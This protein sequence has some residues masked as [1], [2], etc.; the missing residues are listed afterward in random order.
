MAQI[1]PKVVDQC[2]EARDFLGCA[3]AFTSPAVPDDGLSALRD[4]M[5]RVASRLS[6]GTSLNNSSSTF[7]PVIDA[8]A[9]VPE[10]QQ[11]S[12]AYQSASMAIDLFDLTQ[13]V[14]QSRI[15]NTALSAGISNL[16]GVTHLYHQCVSFRNQVNRSFGIL[17]K[18]VPWS[19]KETGMFGGRCNLSGNNPEKPLCSYVVGILREGATNPREIENYMSEL[20]DAKRLASLGPWKRYLEKNQG[21]SAWAKA[22]P[23]LAEAKK[24]EY[25]QQHGSDSVDMHDFPASLQY[26]RGTKVEAMITGGTTSTSVTGSY[27]SVWSTPNVNFNF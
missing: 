16:P 2:N 22:N 20:K 14:W 24:K 7:Q 26:L 11:A 9:V 13:S 17:G 5:K 15:S 21:I 10:N 25:I 18:Y 4:A 27:T 3:K 19:F 6:S 12:I 23:A 1:D 8:H